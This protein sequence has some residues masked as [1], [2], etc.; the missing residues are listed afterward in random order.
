LPAAYRRM[1][2]GQIDAKPLS[3]LLAH[4]RAP[5]EDYYVAARTKGAV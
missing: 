2:A 5:L 4:V 1:R 3:V